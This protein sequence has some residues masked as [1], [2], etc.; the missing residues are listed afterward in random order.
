MRP[1]ILTS[2]RERL[3]SAA[4]LSAVGLGLIWLYSAIYP[5][6]AHQ[7]AAYN[8]II[9]SI[10]PS[11][12]KAFGASGTGLNSLGDFLASKQFGLTWPL[13]MIF[14]GISLAG[15]ML[16]QEI[17]QTT[18]GLW[19]AAPVSRAKVY[20]SKYIAGFVLLLI[21]VAFSVL[22]IIPVARLYHISVNTDYIWW[23]ALVGFLYSW[24]VFSL[25]VLVG[26]LVS[27]RSRLYLPVGLLLLI[28]FV[29]NVVADL[30]DHLTNLKYVSF[31]YYFS[32]SNIL[33]GL[34][35]NH[36][37]FIVFPICAALCTIA[38]LAYFRARDF[39][40]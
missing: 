28:M 37:S 13:L 6:L 25:G 30:N 39:V 15:A 1:M 9:G 40:I 10:S 21:A 33:N 12:L 23:L 34:G 19:L 14:L 31:F 35:T 4:I 16:T 36:V 17:E 32:P 27:K 8:R 3:H 29:F 38:G 26:S 22:S 5:S 2:L 18:L 24:A 11:I 7:S 20:W